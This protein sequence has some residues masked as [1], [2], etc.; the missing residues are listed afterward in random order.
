M[1]HVA[2]LGEI[3]FLQ[4]CLCFRLVLLL[5]LLLSKLHGRVQSLAV[6]DCVLNSRAAPIVRQSAWLQVHWRAVNLISSDSAAPVASYRPFYSEHSFRFSIGFA[7][8]Y[9][10]Y[11]TVLPLFRHFISHS[12]ITDL[13]FFR[14]LLLLYSHI[15]SICFCY[16]HLTYYEQHDFTFRTLLLFPLSLFPKVIITFKFNWMESVRNHKFRKTLY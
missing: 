10:T 3:I 7:V 16:C 2:V 1:L 9:A 8:I 12:F 6:A 4:T 5:L 13:L 11:Y 14:L 15:F